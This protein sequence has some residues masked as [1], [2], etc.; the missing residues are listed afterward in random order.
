[1]IAD[2]QTF[3]DHPIYN[4]GKTKIF[5]QKQKPIPK[6]YETRWQVIRPDIFDRVHRRL[7]RG[8]F[9]MTLNKPKAP[10]IIELMSA[11]VDKEISTPAV[12]VVIPRHIKTMQN[13]LDTDSTVQNRCRPDDGTTV[14]LLALAC[15]GSSTLVGMPG[16]P[17]RN[18]MEFASNSD[19]DYFSSVIESLDS[20]DDSDS[21]A[22]LH[23]TTGVPEFDAQSVS[24]VVCGPSNVDGN[25]KHGLGISLVTKDGSRS[26]RG[27]CGGLLQLEIPDQAPRQ[28]GLMAGHLLEQLGQ[29]STDE[30]QKVTDRAFPIGDIFYPKSSGELPRY[31]W[32]LFDAVG[33]HF[34]QDTQDN[35]AVARELDFP[36]VNTVV[37]IRTSSG[38]MTGTM[39]FSTSGIMLNP[40][41]GFVHVRTIMMNKGQSLPIHLGTI[42]AIISNLLNYSPQIGSTITKGDSGAWVFQEGYEK[43]YG[44]IIATNG[45][46]HAYMVPLHSVLAEIQITLGAVC[47]SLAISTDPSSQVR[48]AMTHDQIEEEERSVPIL[49]E[50]EPIQSTIQKYFERRAKV[51]TTSPSDGHSVIVS[52]EQSSQET[53]SLEASPSKVA[54]MHLENGRVLEAIHILE[55]AVEVSRNVLGQN[56]PEVLSSQHELAVAHLQNGQTTEAIRLLKHV[57]ASEA[58]ILD[59]SNIG[60]LTS[61]HEL[62]RAFLAHGQASEAIDILEHVVKM[63]SSILEKS[64]PHLLASQMVLAE[65]YLNANRPSEAVQVLKSVVAAARGTSREHEKIRAHSAEWLRLARSRRDDLD[66]ERISRH[67]SKPLSVFI[68]PR[69]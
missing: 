36:D 48:P 14:E 44:Y 53:E 17:L 10:T 54:K 42:Q 38:E 45:N 19:S 20:T 13:F 9:V 24:V 41:Q 52:Q 46:D 5:D 64:D 69:K 51:A 58:E 61:Q 63:K 65:A 8:R 26:I 11:G 34:E 15:K 62:A 59:E 22:G 67:N 31:D 56:H 49:A 47:V 7:S 16:E 57:V 35:F 32:A 12:V 40:G 27:T 23:A 3:D 55:S 4:V 60:R 37:V 29:D 21:S 28:L 33:L 68:K 2:F 1:M 6:L 30:Q 50:D 43:I 25:A 66:S 39:S 18:D